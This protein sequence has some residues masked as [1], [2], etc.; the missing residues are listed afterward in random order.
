MAKSKWK[1]VKRTGIGSNSRMGHLVVGVAFWSE[2][3][4]PFS[5]YTI[6]L[7]IKVLLACLIPWIW[8]QF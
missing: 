1:S 8:I 2:W 4:W 3:F 5:K 6:H 7:S